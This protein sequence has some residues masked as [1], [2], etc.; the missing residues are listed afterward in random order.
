M[1]TP[2]AHN[3]WHR[4]YRSGA[5]LKIP[6]VR[7]TAESD[8]GLACLA[9]L[10]GISLFELKARY[11]VSSTGMSFREL[12]DAAH[13]LGTPAK[14]FRLTTLTE[15]SL[16]D[17]PVPCILHLKSK[18]FVVLAKVGAGSIFVNDPSKGELELPL[19]V[20]T[21]IL[22]GAYIDIKLTAVQTKLRTKLAPIFEK[23]HDFLRTHWDLWALCIL[24][25]IGIAATS[26]MLPSLLSSLLVEGTDE[27]RGSLEEVAASTVGIVILA[28]VLRYLRTRIQIHLDREAERY[29]TED[30]IAKILALPA[31]IFT[32]IPRGDLLSRINATIVVRDFLTSRLATTVTDCIA[33]LIVLGAIC[34]E[35]RVLFLVFVGTTALCFLS[36]YLVWPRAL[37]I[38]S[39]EL[40][41]STRSQQVLTETMSFAGELKTTKCEDAFYRRWQLMFR[42]HLDATFKRANWQ[43]LVEIVYG[44]QE[45]MVPVLI[46]IVGL[47]LSQRGYLSKKNVFYVFFLA[48]WA[49]STV[50]SQMTFCMQLIVVKL[51]VDRMTGIA[52]LL[53]LSEDRFVKARNF[54]AAAPGVAVQN[55]QFSYRGTGSNTL[56]AVNIQVEAGKITA[57]VG[58]S[59]SG[60]STLLKIISGLLTPD[61][62]DVHFYAPTE[63][64]KVVYLP[65]HPMLFEGTVREN[66]ASFR[67]DIGDSAIA[68]AAQRA[69][70]FDEIAAMPD[71]MDTLIYEQGANLSAGQRQRIAL[72]RTYLS[73]P[74]IL[75]L[76]EFTSDLDPETESRVVANLRLSGICVLAATHRT[77]WITPGE[78]L[79]RLEKGRVSFQG[80]FD[81]Y[82]PASP[83]NAQNDVLPIGIK[84]ACAT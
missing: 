40:A 61:K 55:L 24:L 19:S 54:V 51:N 68:H 22:S 49:G 52:G 25:I 33:L 37:Q 66:I 44:I 36:L 31:R 8:C 14:G 46:L 9:M 60:K 35:S 4:A 7:Q 27:M 30:L 1:S 43:A 65:Q 69:C 3:E 71:G 76:D 13:L 6:L 78:G 56:D 77:G 41:A 63:K 45:K 59:G 39:I 75:L 11:S 67:A 47:Y 81:D 20:A 79:V 83:K 18:H 58:P 21:K 23:V 73:R 74:D 29:L 34:F 32:N 12:I 72:A 53:G 82:S 70:I 84:D 80:T 10:L 38:T 28:L 26:V 15:D 5:E 16:K 42:S 62:G 64:A 50:R 2:F 17:L 57:L 48:T